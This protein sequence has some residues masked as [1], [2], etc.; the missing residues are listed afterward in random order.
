MLDNQT[1]PP[2]Y[3]QF[4]PWF[5]IAV[6][7]VTV[8]VGAILITLAIDTKDTLVKDD[9]YKEGKA[10]NLDLAKT[11]A[12]RKLGIVTWLT[13][14]DGQIELR[15]LSGLPEEKAALTLEFFHPTLSEKDFSVLLNYS[16]QTQT[17]LASTNKNLT[18]KWRATLYPYH[19]E[20]RVQDTLALP[21]ADPILFRP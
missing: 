13:F 21:Q 19:K 5:L 4:W 7:V 11:Q 18:G 8:F 10:I 16:N 20:W 15:F 17:Y 1:T 6:P 12:A 9:Y 14:S 3:K 2:W